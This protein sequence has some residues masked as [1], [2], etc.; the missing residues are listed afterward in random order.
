M[1]NLSNDNFQFKG[2]SPSSKLRLYCKEVYSLVEDKAPSEGILIASI[3]KTNSGYEGAFKVASAYRI[4]KVDS[5][6]P[7]AFPLIA[8]LYNK[9]K[10]QILDW[11]HNRK[12]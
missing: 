10:L 6:N 4:F 3:E 11:H 9:M 1:L 5:K 8:E 2:F 7:E 12:F